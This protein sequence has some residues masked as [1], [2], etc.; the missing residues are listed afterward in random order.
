MSC[1]CNHANKAIACT[2]T[3]CR[4]HCDNADF[5]S[6]DRIQVGTHEMNP[7]MDQCTDCKSFQ[8]K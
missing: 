5:C 3:N 6:L 1:N 4:N 8:L 2:V 7:T